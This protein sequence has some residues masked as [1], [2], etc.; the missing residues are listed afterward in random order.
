MICAGLL[1]KHL[2]NEALYPLP[3]FDWNMNL[4]ERSQLHEQVLINK[5]DNTDVSFEVMKEYPK[6]MM[7]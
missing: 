4:Y 6:N 2:A 3:Q 5:E 7:E 1:F